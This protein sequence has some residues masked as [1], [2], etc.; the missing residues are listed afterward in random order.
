MKVT[1]KRFQNNFHRYE[2]ESSTHTAEFDILFTSDWHIDNPKTDRKKLFNHLEEAKRKNALVIV[3]GDLL[4]LMQGAYDPRKS[5]SSILP[6]HNGDNY[7]DLVINDTANKLIPYAHNIIQINKG[8]HETAVSRRNETDV[9]ER[10]VERINT[11]A[12]SNIQLG[13]YT[14]FISVSIGNNGRSRSF[15]IGYS[16]GNWGGVVTKGVL[17]VQRYSSFLDN[18]D[19]IISGHTHDRWIVEH[20]RLVPNANKGKVENKIQYHVKTGTYKEEF[21]KGEGW[22]VEKIAMPKSI[23]SV[24][25]KVFYSGHKDLEYEFTPTRNYY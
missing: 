22:A 25:C 15:N 8:N 6:Q 10:L 2:I 20:N 1:A 11:L 3:N 12:G 14:G 19:I 16:H 13:A 18:T 5:K 9:L 24:W 21:T 23:G 7:L 4:C 17:S